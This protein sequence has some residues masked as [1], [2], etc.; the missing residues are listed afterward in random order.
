M[1]KLIV[2]LALL[3]MVVATP[4]NAGATS[5][6]LTDLNSVFI[7][8]TALN[9][10]QWTVDGVQQLYLQGFWWR[11]G[12][13]GG[14]AYLGGL[15]TSAVQN[16]ANILTVDYNGDTRFEVTVTYT[17]YGGNPGSQTSD[18]AESIRIH[19]KGGVSSGMHF[20]QYADFDLGGT[21]GDDVLNFPNANTVN[22][23]DSGGSAM[24]SETVVAPAASHHEGSLYPTLFN[25][26]NDSN[27]TTL[28]DQPPYGGG[29]ISGDVAWGFQWDTSLSSDLIISKDKHLSQ[30]PEPGTL[31]LL[32]FGLL[33][34]E[35]ARRRRKRG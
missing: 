33:G 23:Q 7:V 2:L 17:L 19:N 26:L 6:T 25:S 11:V 35:V 10:G 15:Y 20:F 14:E 13:T 21:A 9:P 3:A 12:T 29:S 22:Q 8:D 34:A 27:P 28:S 31:V 32:G 30:V 24:L 18:V 4:P 16:A 5:W 1:R